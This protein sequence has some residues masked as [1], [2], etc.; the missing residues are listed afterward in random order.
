MSAMTSA[1]DVQPARGLHVDVDVRQRRA[2]LRQEPI[3]QQPVFEGVGGGDV[4]GVAHHR[5]GARPAR[6]HPHTHLPHIRHHLPDGQE[7]RVH[8]QP[9]DHL[10]LPRETL[11]RRPVAVQAA[12]D[13][14]RLA[15]LA[16]HPRG[17]LR[18]GTDHGRLGEVRAAQTQVRDR[19]QAA[20]VRGR[21]GPGEQGPRPV[22]AGAGCVRD[23]LRDRGHRHRALEPALTRVEVGRV[24]ETDR[25]QQPGRVQ[26]VRDP[27]PTRI[28]VTHGV[29]QHGRHRGPVG[30][31]QG[32]GRQAQ[33]TRLRPDNP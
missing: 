6:R 28:R 22:G 5:T 21:R 17:R 18:G 4:Q 32:A 14:S 8:P 1:V 19:I 2:P 12:P 31:L 9:C 20:L 29:G 30:E 27:V 26:H 7:V 16:Q 15:T 11:A 23:P 13:Q 3:E 24:R 25:P 33:R 10:Q